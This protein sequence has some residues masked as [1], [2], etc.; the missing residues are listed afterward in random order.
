MVSS[1]RPNMSKL[2]LNDCLSKLDEVT[3]VTYERTYV[4]T[5]SNPAAVK[6]FVS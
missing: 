6:T 3:Y 1:S 5:S 2:K 4:R